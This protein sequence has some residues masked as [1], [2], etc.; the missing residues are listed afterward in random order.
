MNIQSILLFAQPAANGAKGGSGYS[1][2]IFL[3]LMILVFIS[4]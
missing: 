3:G 1:M 2:L 4:L